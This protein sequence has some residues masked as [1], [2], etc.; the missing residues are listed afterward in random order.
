MSAENV[1]KG[2]RVLIVE[3]D[4]KNAKRLAGILRAVAGEVEVRDSL[5]DL[6]DPTYD[7]VAV[8]YD[9]ISDDDRQRLL[10][11]FS[12][13][14]KQTC[15]LLSAGWDKETYVP[16]FRQR[17]LTNLVAKNNNDVDAEALIVTIKKILLDD[18]FGIEKYFIWGV[19]AKTKTISNSSKRQEIIDSAEE[20]AANLG[21]N[22]RLV[23]AFTL[24][25][26]ELVT[27][28]LYNAPTDKDGN[29]RFAHRSRQETV[30]LEEHEQVTIKFCSDGSRI[31]I[32]AIDPFGS[33]EP[34]KLQDYLAKC[35]AG[36]A[37]QIDDKA[38]GAGLGFYYIFDALSHFIVNIDPGNKTEV[39]GLINAKGGFK[40]FA[41]ENKSFNIF[42]TQGD[43]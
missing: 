25:A 1:L 10:E 20:F 37:A 16:L 4:R 43:S 34:S 19:E 39:I 7:L 28:A 24:V 26:D 32:A 27:N 11:S 9:D 14:T 42:V 8:G 23:Q 15:L 31:G 29:H 17:T 38:G 21:I 35:L 3:P 18:I 22:K 33:L 13:G 6:P 41:A 5:V 2:S 30:E 40:N 36:G 12:G